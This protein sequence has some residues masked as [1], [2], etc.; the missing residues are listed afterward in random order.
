MRDPTRNVLAMALLLTV[1][2]TGIHTGSVPADGLPEGYPVRLSGGYAEELPNSTTYLDHLQPGQTENYLIHLENPEQVEA[3]Y[4]ITISNVPEDW[5]VFLGDNLDRT[6]YFDMD[7]LESKTAEMFLKNLQ[8]ESAN[9]LINV[10]NE[11]TGQYWTITLRIICRQGPL[12]VDLESGTYIL[13]RDVAAE[14][15]MEVS[16]IG[17][18]VL[19]VSLEMDGFVPSPFPLEDSWAVRFSERNFLLP[20]GATKSLKATVWSPEFEPMG[21]QRVTSVKGIVEGVSRPYLSPSF[22]VRVSTIFDLRTSVAPIGYQKVNPG[23]SAGFDV[24]LENWAIETDYVIINEYSTPSGWIIGWEGEIDPTSF[25]ISISPESS[26]TFHAMVYVPEN[27]MAGKHS[28]IMKA[29]GETNVTDI[30]LKVEVARKDDMEAL[31]DTDVSGNTYRMTLGEN[32]LPFTL[33]NKGNFYD[34]VSLEIENRPVWSSVSFYRVRIGS[35]GEVR[36]VSGNEVLNV[37]DLSSGLFQFDRD[38]LEKVVLSLSPSQ[39]I[40]V[41]LR[42]EIAMDEQPNDGVIGVKYRYGSLGNQKFLQMPLKLI[43]VDLEIVDTNRDGL[44]DLHVWPKP[45]YEVGDRI[46]FT[47][48]IKNNYPYPTKEGDV[49][50]KI[51]LTGTVL[52]SGEIGVIQPGETKRFNVTWK[53]DAFTNLKNLAFLNLYGDVYSNE[54]ESPSAR[55]NEEIFVESNEMERPWGFMIAFLIFMVVVILVF[56]GIWML[57]QKSAA[58][59]ER[60]ERERYEEIYGSKKRGLGPDERSR[61]GKGKKRSYLGPAKEQDMRSGKDGKREKKEKKGTPGKTKKEKKGEQEKKEEG[62]KKGAPAKKKKAPKLEEMEEM[63]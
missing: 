4:R 59:K 18:S 1:L 12:V 3:R 29:V 13:G 43:I 39:T 14:I 48:D 49:K 52:V 40:T 5:V 17:D 36:N 63:E 24:T 57:S 54:D 31:L 47:F 20:P 61:L 50:Y 15:P 41:V 58:E 21:S 33:R 45:D 55:T 23:S 2:I 26:R 6:I 28:V 42:S 37:S 30:P 16:N 27:A 56:I 11:N 34:T 25:S 46:H 60:I 10:S 22:T 51:E 7:P 32:N 53:A 9:I 35:G 19:N 44:P 62:K 8:E 38:D